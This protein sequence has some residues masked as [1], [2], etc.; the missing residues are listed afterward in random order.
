MQAGG[1][2]GIVARAISIFAFSHSSEVRPKIK[3]CAP[4]HAGDST[5]VASG[6]YV[7]YGVQLNHFDRSTCCKW[8]SSIG[9]LCGGVVIRIGMVARW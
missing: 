3:I 2:R 5:A 4:W 8:A 9:T 1:G 6:V 7:Q